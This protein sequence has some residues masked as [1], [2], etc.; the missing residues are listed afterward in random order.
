MIKILSVSLFLFLIACSP[1]QFAQIDQVKKGIVE[2][3]VDAAYDAIIKTWCTFPAESH[4]RALIRKT[5][6]PRSLTDNCPA[7]KTIRD[8]LISDVIGD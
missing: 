8:A 4:A 3:R 2:P 5:I 1:A 6:T 7:W